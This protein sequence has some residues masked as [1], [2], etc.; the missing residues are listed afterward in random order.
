MLFNVFTSTT[1]DDV[2]TLFSFDGALFNPVAATN[3]ITTV[4]IAITYETILDLS[5]TKNIKKTSNYKLLEYMLVNTNLF[6]SF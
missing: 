1:F 4:H 5:I 6:L 2:S 3:S